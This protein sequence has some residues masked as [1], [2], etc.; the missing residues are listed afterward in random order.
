[1]DF[2]NEKPLTE[3]S[4]RAKSSS[5]I[6]WLILVVIVLGVAIVGIVFFVNPGDGDDSKK[7]CESKSCVVDELKRCDSK[8]IDYFESGT[9]V[10]LTII[11]I[12][13]GTCEFE[14]N[15]VKSKDNIFDGLSMTCLFSIEQSKNYERFLDDEASVKRLCNGSFVDFISDTCNMMRLSQGDSA[16]DF[17]YKFTALSQGDM[18]LCNKISDP[19]IKQECINEIENSNK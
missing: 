3:V 1:M 10:E 7:I 13:D 8:M 19:E 14:Y 9:H 5:K 4:N 17:C 6:P 18:G 16:A 15:I 2:P 12:D 11:G